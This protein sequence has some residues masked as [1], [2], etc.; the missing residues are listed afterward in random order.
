[1]GKIIKSSFKK[2]VAKLFQILGISSL[3]TAFGCGNIPMTVAYGTV[4]VDMY[5]TPPNYATSNIYTLTGS[6]VDKNSKPIRG[7]KIS[8]K[9]DDKDDYSLESNYSDSNGY[10]SLT[11]R[12]LIDNDTNFQIL[13][14]DEDGEENG[15]FANQ[16]F[17]IEFTEDNKT[18][19]RRYNIAGKN[20]TLDEESDAENT[21]TD[22][23]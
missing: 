13:V 5:G 1:M 2:L 6:I 3:M 16:T 15:L 4:P 22:T 21:E 9:A 17:N 20:I 14:E 8:V 23:E 18:D 19:D 10:Y 12:D 11:W 7:I